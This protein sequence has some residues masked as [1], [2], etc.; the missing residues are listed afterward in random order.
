MSTK[1]YWKIKTPASGRL[2]I[3]LKWAIERSGSRITPSK[4]W[5]EGFMVA[6]PA[7]DVEAKEQIAE[8][9]RALERGEEVEY[10]LR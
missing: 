3:V 4:D 2:P 9:L 7:E 6:L 8:L 1:L 5:L 10:E